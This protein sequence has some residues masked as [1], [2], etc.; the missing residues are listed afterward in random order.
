MKISATVPENVGVMFRLL[1]RKLHKS[2]G[3]VMSMFFE[4]IAN[5]NFLI[6]DFIS[7]C[8]SVFD[9]PT[10]VNIGAR[11]SVS[12]TISDELFEKFKY[13]VTDELDGTMFQRYPVF[14]LNSSWARVSIY[15]AL[16]KFPDFVSEVSSLPEGATPAE[17]AYNFLSVL[18]IVYSSC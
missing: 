15:K 11:T 7:L 14:N 8:Q 4:D 17:A 5:R 18:D 10:R 9:G 16:Q 3:E 12:G 13:V 1:C 6:A 2:Q